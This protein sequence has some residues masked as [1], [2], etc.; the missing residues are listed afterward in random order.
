MFSK[1]EQKNSIFPVI[2]NFSLVIYHKIKYKIIFNFI[3]LVYKK[4]YN[5]NKESDY[6]LLSMRLK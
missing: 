1:S 6:W 5:A 2:Q 3:D 4:Y